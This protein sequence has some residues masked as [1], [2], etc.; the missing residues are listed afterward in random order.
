MLSPSSF[1]RKYRSTLPNAATDYHYPIR[2]GAGLQSGGSNST[3]GND[4]MLIG[5][6]SQ[7][8]TLGIFG[9][10]ALDIFFRIR[11]SRTNLSS[12]NTA[13]R[14][15]RR[16]KGFL[17]ALFLAYSTILIRCVYRIAEMAG[18]W[19]NPIMQN[20]IAFIILDGM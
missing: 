2:T 20:Q 17:V 7:V 10:M 12:S 15:S 16:F 11:R 19:S 4:I 3:V 8:V 9:L 1:R 5:I 18:G 13:L 14:Q 6:V